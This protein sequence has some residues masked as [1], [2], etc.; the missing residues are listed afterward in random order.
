MKGPDQLSLWHHTTGSD[1]GTHKVP[2]NN[3]NFSNVTDVLTVTE[4]TVPGLYLHS[5]W[6]WTLTRRGDF[7]PT[8]YSPPTGELPAQRL[9]KVGRSQTVGKTPVYS[10]LLQ[11]CF[12]KG[13]EAMNIIFYRHYFLMN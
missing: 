1:P 3:I 5:N 9:P 13:A 6:H 12:A 7:D 8:V 4:A 11:G 2:Q 10:V